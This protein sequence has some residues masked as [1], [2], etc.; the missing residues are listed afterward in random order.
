[1][2]FINVIVIECD[3]GHVHSLASNELHVDP[4]Q[5]EKRFSE[6]IIERCNSANEEDI[7]SA[8]KNGIYQVGFTTILISKPVLK[9]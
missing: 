3:Y 9:T 6:L 4:K 5:A 7:K 1:M 2:N 8:L